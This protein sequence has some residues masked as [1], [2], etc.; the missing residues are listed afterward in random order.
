MFPL[1]LCFLSNKKGKHNEAHV[2]TD[3][4]S[5]GNIFVTVPQ[6]ILGIMMKWINQ[7]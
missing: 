1:P 5:L 7:P 6:T 4:R 2:E 3:S